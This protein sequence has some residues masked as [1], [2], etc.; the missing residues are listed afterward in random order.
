MVGAVTASLVSSRSVLALVV[1]AVAFAVYGNALLN[2]FVYDDT[3]LVLSNPWIKDTKHLGDIFFS[4]M[5][6]FGE[7]QVSGASNYYRP[8][9]HVIYMACHQVFGLAPWGFHL[10][11]VLLH[12]GVS[13]LVFFIAG[14]FFHRDG[15]EAETSLAV[16]L[17]VALLF[18]VHPLHTEAVAWVGAVTEPAF[19]FFFLLSLYFY[20]GAVARGGLEPVRYAG[21]IATFFLA[22]LCKEPAI[23]LPA[24]LVA[25]DYAFARESLRERPFVHVKRYAPYLL[26][27]AAYL[28]LRRVA[29]G[30]L[31]PLETHSDLGLTTYQCLINVVPLFLKYAEKLILPVNL[32]AHYAFHIESLG[33]PWGIASLVAMPILG[34][35]AYVCF[36]RSPVALLG[37]VLLVLPL[38]P[39]LYIKAVQVNT[40]AERY[41]YLPSFGFVL[42]VG[43]LLT[44]ALAAR[45][46]TALPLA[47]LGCLIFA[48]LAAATVSR[49]AVWRSDSTFWADTLQRPVDA[50][51]HVSWGNR[52]LARGSLAQAGEQFRMAI[53]LEPRSP[54]AHNSL[55]IVFGQMNEPDKAIAHFTIAARIKP[56][57]QVYYNL[58]LAYR[59]KGEMKAAIEQ[60]ER[61]LAMDPGFGRARQKL[62]E[63]RRTYR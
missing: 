57:V 36:R 55:G 20:C 30:A 58:G 38:A 23:A 1:F 35:L 22:L 60:F 62:A 18:A 31:V 15:G 10:V 13:V 41:A 63:L 61:A 32:S 48:L 51:L 46:K 9:I 7:G 16:P 28:V 40:M 43:V 5:W 4:N 39:V 26:V 34:Y 53:Q 25:Y 33:E 44:R 47:G 21:S 19:S 52:L 11:G 49:N 37:L 42:L 2:G 59:S 6:K 14:L 24:V 17:A 8:L 45:P 50:P 12:A 27:V 29:L 3:F 54:V 56:D